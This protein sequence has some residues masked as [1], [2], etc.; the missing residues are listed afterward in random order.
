VQ[1]VAFIPKVCPTS[2]FSDPCLPGPG[3]CE[4]IMLVIEAMTAPPVTVTP[5]TPIVEAGSLMLDLVI[6]ALP[7]VDSSGRLVGMVSRSDLLRSRGIHDPRAHMRPVDPDTSTPPSTVGDV[8]S[9]SP[10]TVPPS[11]DEAEAV[12]LMLEY[13]FKSIPVVSGDSLVGVVSVTDILRTQLRSDPSVAEEVRTLLLDSDPRTD[14]SVT[15]NAGVV[16]IVGP[17]DPSA[18]AAAEALAETVPGVL[19]VRYH[20]VDDADD[21]GGGRGRGAVAGSARDHRGMQVLDFE[22][23]LKRLRSSPVG[24]LAFVLDGTPVILPVNH[25][26]DGTTVVFATT[27]GSKLSVAE[28]AEPVAFEVDGFEVARR[29]GWSVLVKGTASRVYDGTA[30]DRYEK[31]LLP[32]WTPPVEEVVW[33]AIRP[34][35][36]TGRV[37]S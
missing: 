15:A 2:L 31:L 20:P 17:G 3:G 8:M 23:C 35:E 30:I 16:T 27:W 22:D 11:A 26:V 36:I 18:R 6:T 33:I 4:V 21:A 19:R 7:V 12:S 34:D 13:G 5:E 10:V 1:G 24:R 29:G 9:A 32:S 25:A 14:W 28:T 37:T